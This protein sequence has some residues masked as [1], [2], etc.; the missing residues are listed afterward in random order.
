MG[1]TT[2]A[3]SRPDDDRFSEALRF[4]GESGITGPV[5]LEVKL[6]PD[7]VAWVIEPTVGRTDYWVECCTGNGVNLVYLEYLHQA[8]SDLPDSAQ[9]DRALWMD[10]ER[11]PGS[12][13]RCF[14]SA[15]GF[16]ARGKRIA[17]PYL[18]LNDLRPFFQACS[19]SVRN[20]FGR[21][22]RVGGRLLCGSRPIAGGNRAP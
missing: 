4:F 12:L 20:T 21:I 5:S 17:F 13:I 15:V 1:G 11:D 10:T 14:W 19:I 7:G 2:V 22:V 8:G 3:R 9:C 18:H 16:V 6:A